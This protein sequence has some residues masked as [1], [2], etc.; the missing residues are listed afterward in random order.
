MEIL[1]PLINDL[2]L[3]LITAAVSVVLFKILKQ[4]LVL[5]YIIAGYLA[6]PYFSFLP[7][8]QD[9]NSIEVWAEIGVIFLLFS[10]GL[11]FSFK[12]LVE[13]GGSAFI[14]GVFQAVF[15]LVAGYLTGMLLGWTIID[16][17]FLGAMLSMSSTT[18]IIKS[19]EELNLKGK[20]F[21]SLI[22]G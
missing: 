2:G 12:K 7:T 1:P 4:P 8:V 3:I 14:T 5:G 9:T 11:E 15:M 18:I 17:I 21:V 6:G 13:V 19:L 20:K 16:S 10:L 22:F